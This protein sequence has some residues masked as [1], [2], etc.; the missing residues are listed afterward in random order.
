MMPLSEWPMQAR[1]AIR[2]VLTD[3]DDTLTTGGELTPDVLTALAR[4][5]AARVR[6][7]AVTGR[8][9]YWALP[10]LRL[11]RFDAVIAENGASAFWL[12]GEGRQQSLFYADIST[13]RE[14]RR[15]LDAFALTLQARF[16]Q[17]PVADDAPQRVADLAFDIGEN[18]PRLASDQVDEITSFMRA[19]GFFATA[20]SIHA[21]ASLAAFSKQAMSARILDEVF[22]TDDASARQQFVFV[23]DSGND[24]S[25]FAH[26]PNAIGV[27]NIAPF[28]GGLPVPPA[29]VTRLACGAGFV[30]VVN[31]ILEARDE[32]K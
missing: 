23:G 30:E 25:M 1:R 11:C 16:P 22:G 21:H 31:A 5:R 26:Y 28:L 29:Y 2:G 12:D 7:I 3:I 19:H 20:S 32:E 6:L 24:A 17:V 10:L 15:R 14:H 27:A 9:T 4:L 8:P 18:M 13:R